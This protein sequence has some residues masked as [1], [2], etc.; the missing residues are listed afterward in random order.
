[1]ALA[2]HGARV[3][4][5]ARS[6]DHLEATAQ[7]IGAAGGLAQS[8]A[9][10]VT[11]ATDVLE[12]LKPAVEEALGRP[13]VL[14]NCA[15]TYGPIAL[16]QES[17]PAHWSETMAVNAIAAYLTCRAFVG[18]MVAQGWGRIINVSSAASLHPPSP[19]TSAYAT[20]KVALNHL[21][22][23]LAAEVAGSGVTANAL[24]PGEVKT[25]MW[26]DIRDRAAA[27]GPA[28]DGLRQWAAWVEQTG[29]DPPE[30]AAELVLRLVRDEAA[31]VNGQFLWIEGGL[32]TAGGR[33]WA[34]DV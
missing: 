17:D 1:M 25:A 30:K 28:G 26:Q 29:G 16:I 9:A 15:G 32:Q 18:S 3:A 11:S 14:V 7:A 21:T 6:A 31:G 23:C 22:R 34:D 20:S 12:R 19:L 2:A 33:P 4:L 8:F 13:H 27:L 10:D 24:H 5:V